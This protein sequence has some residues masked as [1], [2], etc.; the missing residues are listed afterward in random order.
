M[1]GIATYMVTIRMFDELYPCAYFFNDPGLANRFYYEKREFY[2]ENSLFT[3]TQVQL[4]TLSA[5]GKAWNLKL[6]SDN[7]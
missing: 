3:G 4:W 5:D 7:A 1:M 2:K 6:S